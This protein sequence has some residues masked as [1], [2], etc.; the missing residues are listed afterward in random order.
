VGLRKPKLKH[1]RSERLERAVKLKSVP[2]DTSRA[3]KNNHDTVAAS[4]MSCIG[5]LNSNA[6]LNAVAMVL[7]RPTAA[8]PYTSARR[9][10]DAVPSDI[11]FGLY[12]SLANE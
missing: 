12:S 3:A 9:F 5:E 6:H 10:V 11:G 1:R 4:V 2:R 8:N 7:H